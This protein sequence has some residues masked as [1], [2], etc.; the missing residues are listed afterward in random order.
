MVGV[1]V[2]TVGVMVG[3]VVGVEVGTVGVMVG[4]AVRVAVGE[5]GAC[6]SNP[7]RS[8]TATES[9]L[10]SSGRIRSRSSM[11]GQAVSSPESIAGLPGSKA[12]VKAWPPL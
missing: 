3:V 1:A 4:L 12:C 6:T 2:S 9:P 10:P 7:P 8:Q 11:G 5:R